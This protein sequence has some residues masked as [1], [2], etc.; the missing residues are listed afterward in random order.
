LSELSKSRQIFV[1]AKDLFFKH[2]L[3]KVSINEICLNSGVSK[4]TFYRNFKNKKAVAL[5][6]I[7]EFCDNGAEDYRKIMASEL[8]YYLKIKKIISSKGEYSKGLSKELLADINSGY[9]NEI[10]AYISNYQGNFENELFNDFS[11][12]QKNGEIRE[13][14][15]IEFLIYMIRDINKKIIDAELNKLYESEEAVILEL[16]KFFFYGIL[17][18]K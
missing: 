15:K 6:I 13:G 7:K 5:T 18:E 12:A 4:M 9:F 11:L 17:P 16:T 8:P 2:G 10:R 1:T 14:V 3:R